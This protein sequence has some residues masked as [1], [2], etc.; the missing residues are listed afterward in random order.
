MW[1]PQLNDEQLPEH[2]TSTTTIYYSIHVLD[3]R[4]A[5][6]ANRPAWI[7][8]N[9]V[10]FLVVRRDDITMPEDRKDVIGGTNGP[11]SFDAFL[12]FSK[13]ENW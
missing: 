9:S 13:R 3:G 1:V 11:N 8:C 2:R 6:E 10:S 4:N 12:S 7:E 5:E